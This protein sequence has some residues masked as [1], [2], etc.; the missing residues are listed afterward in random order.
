[1]LAAA[2]SALAANWGLAQGHLSWH[3]YLVG[4]VV[5]GAVN[6]WLHR[7]QTRRVQP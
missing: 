7:V 1:M 5:I 6:V 4:L 3:W 2:A